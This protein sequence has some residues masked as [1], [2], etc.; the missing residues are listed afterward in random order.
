MGDQADYLPISTSNKIPIDL[1]S[2]HGILLI[3]FHLSM[4]ER[5]QF[6]STKGSS[7]MP[8]YMLPNECILQ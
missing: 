1:K 5:G 3:K 2:L 7:A 8:R 6:Q 4:E